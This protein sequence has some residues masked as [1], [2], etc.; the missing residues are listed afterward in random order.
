M[1]VNVYEWMRKV[2]ALSLLVFLIVGYDQNNY[3]LSCAYVT[4][5]QVTKI[6]A[7]VREWL[8]FL[9]ECGIDFL[10]ASPDKRSHAHTNVHVTEMLRNVEVS[11]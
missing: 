1:N 9:V 5:V 7:K 2:I 10:A 6:Q 8:L 11:V 4:L 3:A